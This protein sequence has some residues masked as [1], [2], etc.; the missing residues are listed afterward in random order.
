MTIEKTIK[1]LQEFANKHS[2]VLEKKGEIGFGRACVGFMHGENFI[3]YN[4]TDDKTYKYILGKHDK[5]LCSPT[6]VNSYH[7]GDYM[8]VLVSDEDYNEGLFQMLKWVEHIGSQGEVEV[9]E[10]PTGAT[11]L[12]AL[13]SGM[14]A[15]AIKL[16]E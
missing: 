12:Q 8:A 1:K 5:R 13:I 3:S 10:Y 4:P 15:K 7:K 16:K 6:G 2:V 9:V 11:G 14:Y